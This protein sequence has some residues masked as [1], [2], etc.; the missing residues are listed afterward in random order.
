[1]ILIALGLTMAR[2]GLAETFVNQQPHTILGATA[3]QNRTTFEYS[4]THMQHL[5]ATNT[6]GVDHLL[7]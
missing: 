3:N 7:W 5:H 2:L 1:M 4:D 6:S